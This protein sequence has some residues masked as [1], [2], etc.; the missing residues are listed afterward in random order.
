M[1]P[2]KWHNWML[3][4]GNA[5]G[6]SV[7]MASLSNKMSQLTG[8]QYF[9]A[10]SFFICLISII[11]IIM[12][13]IKFNN[14]KTHLLFAGFESICAILWMVLVTYLQQ[15]TGTE[16]P[17]EAV[18]ITYAFLGRIVTLLLV[19]QWSY[20]YALCNIHEVARHVASCIFLALSLFFVA[21]YMDGMAGQIILFLSLGVSSL[22][23]IVL[24]VREGSA[25]TEAEMP[26]TPSAVLRE[27]SWHPSPQI[28]PLKARFLFLGSRVLYGIAIGSLVAFSSLS[29][30]DSQL[31]PTLMAIAIALSF[32]A[33]LL[34]SFSCLTKRGEKSVVATLPLTL[35]LL[36][37]IFFFPAEQTGYL[38]SMLAEISWIAQD[39]FQLPSYRNICRMH[40]AKIA[41]EDKAAQMIAYY[42]TV[43][44]LTKDHLIFSI[45][46][47]FSY[48]FCRLLFI[49]LISICICA[50]VRHIVIYL[51]NNPDGTVPPT[52]EK[53]SA[54]TML[55]KSAISLTPREE[56][57]YAL[58]AAGYSRAY[59]GKV[60]C[61]SPDTVKV[62]TRHIYAKL[63]VNT[64]DDLIKLAIS[65]TNSPSEQEPSKTR[66]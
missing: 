64:R 37:A 35:S 6:L 57:V 18:V 11:L 62:H 2:S 49:S 16:A 53:S 3:V 14:I 13:I 38:F 10:T 33:F 5:C 61:I 40:P 20:Q 55:T 47:E 34:T 54:Q 27:D 31:F 26:Y 1:S 19:M 12:T 32:V 30:R 21:L 50:M 66:G 23:N 56:D 17:S 36:A 51:P 63:N 60:L 8:T 25:P 9:N 15:N 59:I 65:S 44:L 7:L 46:S 28:K 58:L 45:N 43:W 22:M 4:V 39:L 29:N 52:T 42:L 48:L 41:Y 24:L